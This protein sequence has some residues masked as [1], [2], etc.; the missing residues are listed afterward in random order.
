MSGASGSLQGNVKS[1]SYEAINID[2][3]I[4]GAEV[5]VS[6]SKVEVGDISKPVSFYATEA[7]DVW[8]FWEYKVGIQLNLGSGGIAADVGA[9]ELPL[10]FSHNDQSEEP[11]VGINKIGFTTKHDVDFGERTTGS[12]NHMYIRT[13]PTL[14]AVAVVCGVAYCLSNGYIPI[15]I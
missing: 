4:A 8:K 14:L 3:I 5:G 12:Y 9:G 11:V 2:T 13:I 15:Y 10:S 7:S 1:E 6:T